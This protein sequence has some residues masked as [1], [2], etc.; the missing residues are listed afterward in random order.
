MRP[1]RGRRL[2]DTRFSTQS[3]FSL[4]LAGI[5]AAATAA[6]AI[7]GPGGLGDVVLSSGT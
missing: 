2:E 6:P 4:I 7:A 3:S 5:I 1:H